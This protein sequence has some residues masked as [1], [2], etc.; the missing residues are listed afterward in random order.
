MRFIVLVLFVFGSISSFACSDFS[1]EYWGWMTDE[2]DKVQKIP[3]AVTQDG[4]K[5]MN[6]SFMGG[7][8]NQEFH[9]DGVERTESFPNADITS[10]ESCTINDEKITC[11]GAQ[12]SGGFEDSI[13]REYTLSTEGIEYIQRIGDF[14][15]IGTLEKAK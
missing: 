2:N 12:F 13:Y 8:V 10:R 5:S 9:F 14:E 3:V 7:Q 11:V 4:C 6:I 15:D 1:G